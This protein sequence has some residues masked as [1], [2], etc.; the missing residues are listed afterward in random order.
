MWDRRG[1]PFTITYS[2]ESYRHAWTKK[3][4]SWICSFIFYSFYS[5]KT[6]TALMNIHFESSVSKYS[7]VSM[8]I[9]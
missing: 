2:S 5:Q 8:Q 9:D 7:V 4:F 3:Y 6:Q 1:K